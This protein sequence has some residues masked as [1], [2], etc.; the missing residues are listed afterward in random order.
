MSEEKQQVVIELVP[1]AILGRGTLLYAAD[2]SSLA[3]MNH[4]SGGFE[5][6]TEAW[7]NQ[8]LKVVAEAHGWIIHIKEKK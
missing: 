6:V 8:T 7:L 3:L 5:A 2:P 4:I 1:R